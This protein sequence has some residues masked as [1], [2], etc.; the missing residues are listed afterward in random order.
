M[1][2]LTRI[3]PYVLL[4]M[5]FSAP[6]YAQGEWS[7]AQRNAILRM[8]T[9]YINNGNTFGASAV[10]GG[11]YITQTPSVPLTNEQ[12]LSALATGCLGSTTATGVVAA[13]T[14]TGGSQISI[15]NGDCSGNPTFSISSASIG[16]SFVA[17]AV[18]PQT[19]VT[20]TV[21]DADRGKLVTLSNAAAIAVTLPDAAGAG[22]DAGWFAHFQNTG[23]GDVVIT[24]T[25]STIDG[26]TDVTL[27]TDQGVSIFSDGTNYYTMRGIGGATSL[28]GETLGVVSAR[29][30]T[31]YNSDTIDRGMQVGKDVNEHWRRGHDPTTGLF[32]YGVCGGTVNGCDYYRQLAPNKKG[33]FKNSDGTIGFEYTEGLGVTK[34]TN[35]YPG[36]YDTTLTSID[37]SVAKT[38]LASWTIPGAVMSANSCVLITTFGTM[39]IT[40]GS[41]DFFFSFG[42]TEITH[43]LTTTTGAGSNLEFHAKACNLGATNSQWIGFQVFGGTTRW[44]AANPAAAV[45]TTGNVTATLSAQFS[46][47]A[48][49]N[50]IF[51]VVGFWEIKK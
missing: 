19:G 33:G 24:P 36:S 8:I 46:S 34:T 35:F 5:A 14:L 6:A 27:I 22:F 13:R 15:A 32:D 11:T 21:D 28:T 51:P 25:T 41:T 45:D 39:Q 31:N 48:T 40:G 44:L 50:E 12:A 38:A 16:P 18:N 10:L 4:L 1:I 7:A 47:A 43:S 20:Y 49:T 29:G 42:G 30:N 3:I 26:N 2:F 9:E 37:N 23:V 17:S